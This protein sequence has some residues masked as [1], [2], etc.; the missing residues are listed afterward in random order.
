[1]NIHVYCLKNLLFFASTAFP[2]TDVRTNGETTR[3]PTI[4]NNTN[5]CAK[6][7]G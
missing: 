7:E 5:F 4:V 3:C 2:F 6:E 1:M